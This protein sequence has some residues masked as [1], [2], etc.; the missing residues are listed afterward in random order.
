[1]SS[2]K[3]MEIRTY[4]KVWEGMPFTLTIVP[5]GDGFNWEIRDTLTLKII[6]K[7]RYDFSNEE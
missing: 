5:N 6:A 4:N 1:M 7:D 2:K 3:K